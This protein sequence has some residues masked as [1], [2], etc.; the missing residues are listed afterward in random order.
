MTDLDPSD[1]VEARETSA[2][3]LAELTADHPDL[4]ARI[5]RHPVAY[6]E[7]L[8][9]I[10]GNGDA[11]A[12]AVAGRLLIESPP[13]PPAPGSPRVADG[14]V[15]APPA[16]SPA[17]GG[18]APRRRRRRALGVG[19][20]VL[21]VVAVAAA[22]VLVVPNLLADESITVA[23]L[24]SAPEASAWS[25]DGPSGAGAEASS[26]VRKGSTVGQD[27]ALISWDVTQ[28]D[29]T[30]APWIALVDTV[31]GE[32]RWSVPLDPTMTGLAPAAEGQRAG[33]WV[34]RPAMADGS[35]ALVLLDPASG[36]TLTMAGFELVGAPSTIDGDLVVREVATN[37]IQRWDIES[38]SAEWTVPVEGETAPLVAGATLLFGTRAISLDDGSDGGWAPAS[39]TSYSV[40]DDRLLGVRQGGEGV[41][42]GVID[43]ESGAFR[44][45]IEAPSDTRLLPIPTTGLVAASS[46]T[47]DAAEVI[48]LD[49]GAT[50]LIAGVIASELR[51]LFG[52]ESA[53]V[54]AVPFGDGTS[55]TVFDLDDGA[56]QFDLALQV[57][58][59][60]RSIIG[61][62]PNLLYVAGGPTPGLQAITADS[63]EEQWTL[64][65]PSATSYAFAVWGG[66]VVATRS[67]PLAAESEPL[68][69][70]LG[71]Q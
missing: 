10:A 33:W 18:R 16:V 14:P 58:G 52:S 54:V 49:D 20:A 66:N 48:D 44:W 53:G 47:A 35:A 40:V 6:P 71:V 26:V 67:T 70:L 32:E 42:F 46:A 27:E 11:E 59:A 24:T 34:M 65:N 13:P 31:D 37:T 61:A 28:T 22:A 19:V 17:D 23:E 38:M 62:T 12:R 1:E 45:S 15:P 8:Q 57:D 50:R 60:W 68:A 39:S 30:T 7:L 9:W 51:G 21:A 55:V 41:I 69:P 63:G 3:R 56:A 4:H 64:E 5:A 36:E 2:A 25:I 43:D 29:G